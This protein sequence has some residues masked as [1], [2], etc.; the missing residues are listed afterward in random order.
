MKKIIIAVFFL[1]FSIAS[2]SQWIKESTS[3]L[4]IEFFLNYIPI[5]DSTANWYLP[6]PTITD[7]VPIIQGE[8]IQISNISNS[9]YINLTSA[10]APNPLTIAK[11]FFN[12]SSDIDIDTGIVLNTGFLTQFNTQFLAP[13]P[14]QRGG[15]VWPAIYSSGH[16]N[17][18]MINGQISN[19]E[20]GQTPTSCFQG[21]ASP[22]NCNVQDS[23]LNSLMS[24]SIVEASIIE[25]DFIPEGDS[26]ALQY[27]F[28]SEEYPN[29]S[30]N[31]SESTFTSTVCDP[32]TDVMGIFLSGPGIQGSKNIALVPDTDLPVGVNTITPPGWACSEGKDYSQY[33]VDNSEGQ[34]VIY[35]G[36]TTVL[37][38]KSE[39]IPGE[40]YHLRIGVADVALHEEVGGDDLDYGD[41]H[42]TGY[43]GSINPRR[44]LYDSG[45]FIKSR[46]LVSWSDSTNTDT[47]TQVHHLEHLPFQII[48]NPFADYFQIKGSQLSG[49][50]YDLTITNLMGMVIA[51]FKGNM[52]TL[53]QSLRQTT[54]FNNQA[55]GIY[56]VQLRDRNTGKSGAAKL[57]KK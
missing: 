43:G 46:S 56:I 39:V 40:T 38:A 48:P 23:D 10:M 32:S 29:F 27:V 37:T 19:G 50:N 8:G 18:M 52:T 4:K 31:F 49:N 42:G 3:N 45:I 14:A 34:N 2:W 17:L 35:N 11:F 5:T 12:G 24:D 13:I 55:A 30:P 6:R 41:C 28:A 16:K 15:I 9:P 47:T 36:F 21:G 22:W 1:L 26:I 54:A 51:T 25:F 20:S 7:I 44:G 33:Y 53:N 57:V